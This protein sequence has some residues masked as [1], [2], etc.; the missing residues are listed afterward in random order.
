MARKD[1]LSNRQKTLQ[2]LF[3]T[4]MR[5][6]AQL[7]LGYGP[8]GQK[9][10]ARCPMCSGLMQGRGCVACQTFVC[11]GCRAWTTGNGGDGTRCYQC[12]CARHE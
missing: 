7:A 1:D 3:P 10:I 8:H 5:D 12:L 9:H 6:S 11:T 4:R 2:A